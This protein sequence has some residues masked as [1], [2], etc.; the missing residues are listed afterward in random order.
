MGVTVQLEFDLFPKTVE[1]K[2]PCIWLEW[3]NGYRYCYLTQT[4]HL[5]C[6][7]CWDTGQTLEEAT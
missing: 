4:Y 1:Q 5:P 3:S 7:W 2:E 6:E